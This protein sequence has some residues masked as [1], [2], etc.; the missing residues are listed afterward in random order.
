MFRNTCTQYT[1]TE[2]IMAKTKYPIE[3]QFVV[4]NLK[5]LLKAIICTVMSIIYYEF[6]SS[7]NKFIEWKI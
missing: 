4:N 5:L 6:I 3:V 1:C 2:T 7:D